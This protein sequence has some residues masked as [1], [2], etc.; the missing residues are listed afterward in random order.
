[1]AA[2]TVNEI[3]N[4]ITSETRFIETIEVGNIIVHEIESKAQDVY[5]ERFYLDGINQL[6]D[7]NVMDITIPADSYAVGIGLSM[8]TQRTAGTLS[9]KLTKNEIDLAGTGLNIQLNE[10]YPLD[11]HNV[12]AVSEDYFF[13]A[14]DK[15]RVIANSAAWTPLANIA[16]LYLIIKNK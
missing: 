11:R 12:I 8:K 4:V 15:L 1:M 2:I 6:I 3:I 14:G 7:A 13:A 10:S 16:S 5:D 9:L